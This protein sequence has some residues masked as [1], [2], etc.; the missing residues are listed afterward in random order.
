MSINFPTGV[1]LQYPVV[2]G[3]EYRAHI[4]ESESGLELRT[5]QWRFPRRRTTLQWAALTAAEMNIL[6]A[7]YQGRRGAELPFF[8]AEPDVMPYRVH[9]DEYMGRGDGTTR[10][11]D[12]P[13]IAAWTRDENW[14]VGI[15]HLV[16]GG[17][18]PPTVSYDPAVSFD[19]G[20]GSGRVV[21]HG[22][23]VV[24]GDTHAGADNT[25]LHLPP[26]TVRTWE[27]RLRASTA[28]TVSLRVTGATH[29]FEMTVSLTTGWQRFALGGSHAMGDLRWVGIYLSQPSS[30][31]TVWIDGARAIW[32]DGTEP[33]IV[34][35]VDGVA[36]VAGGYLPGGGTGGGD[37][38][39]FAT[40]PPVGSLITTTFTG[41]LRLRMR[42]AEQAMTQEMFTARLW[43]AGLSL[44]ETKRA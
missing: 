8:F 41:R 37:R 10:I 16:S 4:S 11:F 15:S 14:G 25:F 43:R 13:G 12:F 27:L 36:N 40:A 33:P 21:W 30:A 1:L 5:R 17:T 18:T 2:W 35:M 19:A 26:A 28:M 6:W 7:F 20:T 3:Q 24:F 39:E 31:G 23:G 38:W 9:T 44:I 29:V 22:P 42:F 34:V 32:G